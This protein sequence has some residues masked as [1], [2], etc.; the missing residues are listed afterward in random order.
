[1]QEMIEIVS[2]LTE[3]ES[4]LITLVGLVVY[5]GLMFAIP[6]M[7]NYIDNKFFKK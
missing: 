7:C 3:T 1:M 2:N 4:A 6:A 5:L